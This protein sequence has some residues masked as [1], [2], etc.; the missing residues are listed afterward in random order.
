MAPASL[1]G[2]VCG[3]GKLVLQWINAERQLSDQLS[4]SLFSSPLA[5][6]PGQTAALF[7]FQALSISYS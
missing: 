5:F 4:N 3:T 1:S 6:I 7:L 2:G